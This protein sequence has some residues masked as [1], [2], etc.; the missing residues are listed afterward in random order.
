MTNREVFRVLQIVCVS[1]DLWDEG[2]S[3]CRIKNLVKG[4]SD[5]EMLFFEPPSPLLSHKRKPKEGLPVSSAV[6][7][8][9]LPSAIPSGEDAGSRIIQRS[10]KNAAFILRRMKEHGFENPILWLRCPDQVELIYELGSVSGIVYDCDQNWS[11]LPRDWEATIA[12]ESDVVLA[13][14]PLLHDKLREYNENVA[15]IPNGLDYESFAAAAKW[16]P[17]HPADLNL[18]LGS[19][20]GFIGKVDD[21]TQLS[22]VLHAA[23]AHPEWSFVFIG[24]FSKQNILYRKIKRLKNVYLFGE[25]SV[26]SLP[27]YLAGFDVCFS[28]LNDKD[29]D[30]VLVSEQLYR[31]MASGKP[32]VAMSGGALDSFYPDVIY[33]AHFD[34]EFTEACTYALEEGG[35]GQAQRR[36]Q[37]SREADWS[38]RSARLWE[39]FG[40][41]G[42]L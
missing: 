5:I 22:P 31:Y 6:T 3:S 28:L 8:Y 18:I 21:F 13:A 24:P 2:S 30:P 4:L 16:Y 26:S 10:R 7:A 33:P 9:T 40:T 32:I 37:Y 29:T 41:N 35:M 20:F 36:V 15:L 34:L 11:A 27:R 1:Y 14:S 39:V 12:V 42:F 38:N 19:V 17:T 25:K 23:T